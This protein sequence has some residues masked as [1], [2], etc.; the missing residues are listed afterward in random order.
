IK[1]NNQ[2]YTLDAAAMVAVKTPVDNFALLLAQF[3]ALDQAQIKHHLQQ[4]AQL[5]HAMPMDLASFIEK[6]EHF[7]RQRQQCKLKTLLRNS[8]RITAWHEKNYRLFLR[9]DA[10]SAQLCAQLHD[11]AAKKMGSLVQ[12]SGFPDY[13]VEAH[14]LQKVRQRWQ[15][16]HLAEFIG[17][18]EDIPVA[19]IEQRKLFHRTGY[20][21]Y[22]PKTKRV[23]HA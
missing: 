15:E 7:K 2:V 5:H 18:A 22:K 19:L 11:S 13:V 10:Y 14:P 8:S 16:A 21:I 1:K 12:L 3:W 9:N 17:D 23:Q 6:V 20:F 4:Y